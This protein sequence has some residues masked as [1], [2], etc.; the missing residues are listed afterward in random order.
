MSR[1]LREIVTPF[2]YRYIQLNK[3]LLELSDDTY[4]G[5]LDVVWSNVRRYTRHIVINSELDWHLASELLFGCTNID[6]IE[7]VYIPD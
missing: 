4:T 5:Y 6:R 1:R 2:R 7:Y 3:N